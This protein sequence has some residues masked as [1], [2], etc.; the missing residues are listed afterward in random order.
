MGASTLFK[1]G[2]LSRLLSTANQV[3]LAGCERDLRLRHLWDCLTVAR[4]KYVVLTTYLQQ[5]CSLLI[6][7]LNLVSVISKW[8]PG[9]AATQAR[10]N[11]NPV[12][13]R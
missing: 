13:E 4:S 1:E 12:Q 5:K 7:D 8:Q 6:S 2:A 9:R 11:G 3:A 10:V